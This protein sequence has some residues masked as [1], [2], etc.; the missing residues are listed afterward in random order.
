MKTT[1]GSIEG[2]QVTKLLGPYNYILAPTS[3]RATR[4]KLNSA[5]EEKVSAEGTEPSIV[6]SCSMALQLN[7]QKVRKVNFIADPS[8]RAIPASESQNSEIERFLMQLRTLDFFLFPK[9]RLLKTLVKLRF[10]PQPPFLI[11]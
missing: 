2:I 4:L 9:L 8:F 10:F 3:G 7:T 6:G 1:F 5:R 11:M